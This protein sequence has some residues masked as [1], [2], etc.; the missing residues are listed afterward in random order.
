MKKVPKVPKA[1]KA[2]KAP[3]VPKK[4]VA[5]NTVESFKDLSVSLKDIMSKT[6]IPSGSKDDKLEKMNSVM[7]KIAKYHGALQQDYLHVINNPAAF[8]EKDLKEVGDEYGPVLQMVYYH[9]LYGTY[10]YF[11]ERIFHEDG[12]MHFVNDLND[13]WDK[14]GKTDRSVDG[15][16][17]K[18]ILFCHYMVQ[19]IEDIEKKYPNHIMDWY[20]DK[21]IALDCMKNGLSIFREVVSDKEKFL[22]EVKNLQLA[23]NKFKDF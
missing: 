16:I 5:R 23:S 8:V 9:V 15:F 6:K 21:K 1:P 2:P 20:N 10:S 18:A 19:T 12:V 7:K 14:T 4:K 11:L 17:D 13:F 22:K 3:K